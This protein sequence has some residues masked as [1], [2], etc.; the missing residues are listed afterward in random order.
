MAEN[1]GG[2]ADSDRTELIGISIGAADKAA[3]RDALNALLGDH[4]VID[5]N[6][7][8][9][10]K[11][12]AAGFLDGW[13]ASFNMDVEER[14]AIV[15]ILAAFA[16]LDARLNPAAFANLRARTGAAIRCAKCGDTI[17]WQEVERGLDG[18]L[19]AFGLCF[20]CGDDCQRNITLWAG[21]TA[22]GAAAGFELVSVDD[23]GFADCH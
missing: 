5:L 10:R 9:A 11:G 19:T 4:A 3:A 7:D 1:T 14:N 22:N 21:T 8:G 18:E 6:A 2:R 12:Y 17:Q 15:D 20:G 23:G 13:R 16:G